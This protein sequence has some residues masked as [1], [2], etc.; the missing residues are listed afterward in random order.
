MINSKLDL[1]GIL[2]L[3]K[4]ALLIIAVQVSFFTNYSFF[5]RFLQVLILVTLD[6]CLI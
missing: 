3:G 1:I 2:T 6:S 5:E 4:A